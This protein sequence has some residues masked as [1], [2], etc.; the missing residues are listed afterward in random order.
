MLSTAER[1]NILKM[2]KNPALEM[3][4]NDIKAML[5]AE[6]ALPAEKINAELVKE[7]LTALDDTP[8]PPGEKDDTW[9]QIREQLDQQPKQQSST[10][11]LRR[12]LIAAAAMVVLFGL[13]VGAAKAFRWKFLYTLIE[14]FAETFGI[15][16]NEDVQPTP[17]ALTLNANNNGAAL[18]SRNVYTSLDGIPSVLSGYPIKPSWV[19][20]GYQFVQGT[21]FHIDFMDSFSLLYMN[22]DTLFRVLI[23]I[24]DMENATISYE[25]EMISGATKQHTLNHLDITL[26]L[27]SDGGVSSASWIDNAAKYVISGNVTED[28]MLRTI[29]ELYGGKP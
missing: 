5:E 23:Q 15:Q 17:D 12:V 26:Y 7:L 2:L 8:I 25:H 29:Q 22:G 11:A 1:E 9:Q 28:D 20:E 27:N 21:V 3:M 13:T 19:P 6:L 24:Y 16:L 4:P 18:S 14:P 10:R